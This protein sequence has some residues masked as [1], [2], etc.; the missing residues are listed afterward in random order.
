M[1]EKTKKACLSVFNLLTIVLVCV[2]GSVAVCFALLVKLAMTASSVLRPQQ[3]PAPA[4]VVARPAAKTA[5]YHMFEP[6]AVEL[7]KKAS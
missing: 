4:P 2:L 1:V 7:D 5:E 6:A 3:R